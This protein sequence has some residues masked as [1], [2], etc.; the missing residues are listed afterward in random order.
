MEAGL[1]LPEDYADFLRFEN[2]GEGFIGSAYLILWRVEE[3]LELNRAHQVT[4]HALGFLF[5]GSD[6]GGEAFAFDRRS[7]T[8]PVVRVPFIGMDLKLIRPLASSFT[9]FLE[10]LQRL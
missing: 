1:P 2:G 4:D 5:F 9:A 7:D 8:T 6:G 10:V 3:L